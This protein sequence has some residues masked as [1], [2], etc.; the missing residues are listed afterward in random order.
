[1]QVPKPRTDYMLRSFGYSVTV[2]WNGLLSELREIQSLAFYKKE[3]DD[4]LSLKGTHTT[5]TS[6]KQYLRG[7]SYPETVNIY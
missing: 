1:M 7:F 2:L 4:L 3:L 6:V 5:N